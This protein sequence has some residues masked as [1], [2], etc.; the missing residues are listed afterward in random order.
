LKKVF[1]FS[2]SFLSHDNNTEHKAICALLALFTCGQ[3]GTVYDGKSGRR[4]E[5]EKKE[6]EKEQDV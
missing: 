5:R 2:L 1:H 6:E 3:N 4:S